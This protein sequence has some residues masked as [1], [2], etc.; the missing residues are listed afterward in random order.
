ME[1]IQNFLDNYLKENQGE[2]DYIHGKDILKQL[3]KQEN[4]IGFVLSTID[5]THLFSEIIKKGVLPRK[6]FSMGH[7]KEK[8]YYMETRKIQ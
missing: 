3:S 5:K 4:T 6:T 2:I 7:A 8:R 1:T